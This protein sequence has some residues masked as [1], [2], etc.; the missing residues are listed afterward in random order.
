MTSTTSPPTTG[1]R[2]RW[3]VMAAVI[4]ADVMDL[5]DATIA[6]LA[7]PSIQ[8]DI[9]GTET[10]LQWILAGYTLAFAV[11]L[12]TSARLGDIVGRRPMFIAGMA[13]FTVFSL[14][15]GLAP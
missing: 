9:G 3:Y 10:T 14:L 13:G 4:I 12:L 5:L 2:Y 1:Y 8:A 7:G 11:G 6:T 15:C